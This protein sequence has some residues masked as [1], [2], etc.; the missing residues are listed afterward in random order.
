[1]RSV[2]VLGLLLGL[3]LVACSEPPAPSPAV[4]ASSSAAAA[5]ASSSSA[6]APSSSAVAKP[7]PITGDRWGGVMLAGPNN[8]IQIEIVLAPGDRPAGTISIP[9]QKVDAQPLDDIQY[10]AKKMSF[11]MAIPRVPP[12]L[13]PTFDLERTDDGKVAKGTIS[14]QGVTMKVRFRRLADG[15]HAGDRPQ[16]PKPPYPYDERAAY[17]DGKDGTH[18]GGTLSLPKTGG[19]FPTVV[20]VSGTGPQDRDSNLFGHQP[21]KVIADRLARSG[22]A[23]LRVD[24]RGVGESK[25]DTTTANEEDKA[26]DIIAAMAWLAT[27]P[28]IDPKRV[29]LLGHSE[30]GVLVAMAA[31]AATNPKAAFVILFASPGLPGSDLLRTQM[32]LKLEADGATKEQIEI[33]MKAQNDAIDAVLKDA[34]DADL[35]KIVT[36][37][38][39]GLLALLPAPER[40]K[41]TD[42]DRVERI[43]GGL[44]QIKA[45]AM[46]AF[47]KSK[48]ATFLAKVKCPVLALGG[49]KD[50]QVPPAENL[51]MI[52]SALKKAG[53]KDVTT[54]TF[55]G[56]NHLFQNADTG[57][58]EEWAILDET[59]DPRVLDKLATWIPAHSS[60]SAAP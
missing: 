46:K 38:I 4:S 6:A 24:D 44:V 13:Q 14:Q 11:R 56:L 2:P 57:T 22:I 10:S 19:P 49:T 1:M 33:M 58:M 29:G 12:P 30:G 8:P 36:T 9:A 17:F 43:K 47:I 21:F 48:P 27:Q 31:A 51:G 50:L 3:V 59:L 41:V 28:D 32:R 25:G 45:P 23:V 5:S 35:E 54:E 18:L 16:T 39:D 26:A 37:Q 55:D 52:E 40:K 42:A 15:E 53:N 34:S 60:G 7:G 20:L